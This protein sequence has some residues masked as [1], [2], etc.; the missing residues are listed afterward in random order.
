MGKKKKK[1]IVL[2]P[3]PSEMETESVKKILETF[4]QLDLKFKLHNNFLPN[5]PVQ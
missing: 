2:W 3:L 5:T 1:E 4:E